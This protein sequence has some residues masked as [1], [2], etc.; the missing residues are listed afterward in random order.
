MRHGRAST[1]GASTVLS[2]LS[3]R[4]AVFIVSPTTTY[5]ERS[6]LPRVPDTTGPVKMPTRIP[7]GGRPSARHRRFSSRRAASIES[8][9]ST[10]ARASAA[11][12]ASVRRGT[13]M[14]KTATTESPAY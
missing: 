8:A 3:S 12:S 9:Q 6:A 4:D 5:S 7:V 13:G 11:I 1:S 14:P 2:K 10:E